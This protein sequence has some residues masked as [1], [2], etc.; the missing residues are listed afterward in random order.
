[1]FGFGGKPKSY[2]I[3][4]GQNGR[5]RIVLDAPSF[6][7]MFAQSETKPV[8]LKN[9]QPGFE[10]TEHREFAMSHGRFETVLVVHVG[11]LIAER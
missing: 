7:K 9:G 3:Y 6:A 2:G 1:M 10:F 8:M 5:I 11:D 4:D